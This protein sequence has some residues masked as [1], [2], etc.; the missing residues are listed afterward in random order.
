MMGSEGMGMCCLS[1][2]LPPGVGESVAEAN[3]AIKGER[4]TGKEYAFRFS[5]D[6]VRH[7][8]FDSDSFKSQYPSQT[9][10]Y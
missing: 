5:N 7:V 6:Y 9:Y 8:T 3:C 4:E 2:E 10:S 1:K